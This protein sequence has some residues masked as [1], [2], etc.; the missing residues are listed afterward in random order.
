[1]FFWISTILQEKST[2]VFLFCC[3]LL[4]KKVNQGSIILE[5]VKFLATTIIY[6]HSGKRHETQHVLRQV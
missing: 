1:M 4:L 6:H 5:S 3:I 2:A